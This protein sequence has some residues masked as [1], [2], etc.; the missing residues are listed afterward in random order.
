MNSKNKKIVSILIGAILVAVIGAIALYFYL[1]P[2]KTTVYV[3]K[4]GAKAGTVVTSDM[5]TPIQADSEILVAGASSNTSAQFVTGNNIDEVLKSGDSLRMDVSAGMPL[6]LSMLTANGG[7]AV[8]M[9]MDP[10]KIAITIPITGITGVTNDLKS[11]SRVNIYVTGADVEG[12]YATTLAFQ[13]MRIL[14]VTKDDGGVLTS[15]TVETTVEESLKLV[16]Y[17]SSYS[18]YLGLI[19]S[20]GYEYPAIDTPTF[21]PMGTNNYTDTSVEYVEGDIGDID[22]PPAATEAPTTEAPTT[23]TPVT[24]EPTEAPVENPEE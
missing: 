20:T 12:N 14:T 16:Y 23:E 22:A 13:N 19:D 5:L 10:T 3:F 11:G 1:V 18:I 24:Q 17:S 2:Q 9:S 7:S 6:T 4:N 8:E 15:A 21:S